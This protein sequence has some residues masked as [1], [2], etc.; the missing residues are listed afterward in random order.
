L[1]G[2]IIALSIAALFVERRSFHAFFSLF[3]LVWVVGMTIQ[4]LAPVAAG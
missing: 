1:I 3:F 4:T 2:P